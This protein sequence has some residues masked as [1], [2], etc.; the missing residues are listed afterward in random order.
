MQTGIHIDN[1]C[2]DKAVEAATSGAMMIFKAAFETRMSEA[3]VLKAFD[4]L[5]QAGNLQATVT[6]CNFDSG[7]TVNANNGR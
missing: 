7:A 3:V 6:N 5:Q 2:T 4:A 1:S